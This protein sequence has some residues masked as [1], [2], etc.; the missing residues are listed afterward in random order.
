M[1]M[2]ATRVPIAAKAFRQII[3]R[4]GLAELLVAAG[5]K[6]FR[7]EEIAMT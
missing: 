5:P 1:E 2:D 4:R 3:M 7:I 6:D